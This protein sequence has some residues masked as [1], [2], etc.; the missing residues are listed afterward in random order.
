MSILDKWFGRSR[1][2]KLADAKAAEEA[3]RAKRLAQA[4]LV[5]AQDSEEAKLAADRRLQKIGRARSIA[6]TG[7]A[8]RGNGQVASK[9][10]LGQ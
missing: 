2:A 7:G 9:A 8:V 4:A 6:S 1:T 5:P 3:A 10:L